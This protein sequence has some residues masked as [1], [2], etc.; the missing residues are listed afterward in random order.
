MNIY[1]YI[2]IYI[3]IYEHIYIYIYIYVYTHTIL[4][5]Y[6]ILLYYDILYYTVPGLAER[7]ATGRVPPSLLGKRVI[8]L[9]L[10]LQSSTSKGI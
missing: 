4:H 5:V 10:V 6:Y 8:Q 7:I 3:C 2:Y 1:E 9:D